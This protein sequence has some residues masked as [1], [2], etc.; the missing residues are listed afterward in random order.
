VPSF[1]TG[2]LK[3]LLSRASSR[4]LC[5]RPSP[6]FGLHLSLPPRCTYVCVCVCMCMCVRVCVCVY[7]HMYVCVCVCVR[8]NIYVCFHVR[9]Y[10]VWY[11]LHLLLSF[12]LTHS[13]LSRSLTLA[14]SLSVSF[15]LSLSPSLSL[16]FSPAPVV[17]LNTQR[18]CV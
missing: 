1:H 5:V 14:R 8:I 16:F 4:H 9:M 13:S 10:I 15:S 6:N 3:N 11:L 17:G 2:C 12:F 18:R 7:M